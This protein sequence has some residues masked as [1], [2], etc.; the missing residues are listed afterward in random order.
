MTITFNTA[1]NEAIAQSLQTARVL[2]ILITPSETPA[3]DPPQWPHMLPALAANGGIVNNANTV[4]LQLV[5]D[6]PDYVLFSQ[7]FHIEAAAD[8]NTSYLV[9]IHQGAVRLVLKKGDDDTQISNVYN[10]PVAPS[11]APFLSESITNASS[12]A[13]STLQPPQ[14]D[15]VVST[16]AA[17]T[18]DAELSTLGPESVTPPSV[19]ASAS[20]E[21]AT[22]STSDVSKKTNISNKTKS[23][24]PARSATPSGAD[25]VSPAASSPTTEAATGPA[26]KPNRKLSHGS[27]QQQQ[28]RARILRLLESDRLERNMQRKIAREA[29]LS[30]SQEKRP[31]LED[32]DF[33]VESETIVPTPKNDANSCALQIRLFDGAPVKHI[34]RATETLIDVRTY[35]DKVRPD[36]AAAPYAFFLPLAK[37]TFG[38]GEEAQELRALGLAPSA[39]LVIK[40]PTS[41]M[42]SAYASERAR[43]VSQIGRA[44][45]AVSNALY[46]F[47]GIGYTPPPPESQSPSVDIGLVRQA[48]EQR[49][50]LASGGGTSTNGSNNAVESSGEEPRQVYINSSASSS[51]AAINKKFKIIQTSDDADKSASYNGNHLSLQ[52]DDKKNDKSGSN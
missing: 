1:I 52:D 36:M 15:S 9:F 42:Y 7:I 30:Q 35:L 27:P 34:F 25:I 39:T 51:S 12:T 3:D 11:A 16:S 5:R 24:S 43:P 20:S 22:Y 31:V 8:R 18:S 46:V 6:S 47:L 33:A 29:R 14:S 10:T 38:D 19:L 21:P 2:L 41:S 26:K 17:V 32:G 23:T 48:F 40:P 44:I 4:G 50:P 45:S 28:E 37:K 49:V 13:E